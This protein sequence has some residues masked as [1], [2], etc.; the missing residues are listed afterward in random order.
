MPAWV[1]LS[2]LDVRGGEGLPVEIRIRMHALIA[3]HAQDAWIS[4]PLGFVENGC[5]Q[6]PSYRR[7]GKTIVLVHHSLSIVAL[8]SAGRSRLTGIASHR[9]ATRDIDVRVRLGGRGLPTS[10]QSRPRQFGRSRDRL[11]DR[12]IDSCQALCD[13]GESLCR[14]GRHPAVGGRTSTDPR[15]HSLVRC[16]HLV[17]HGIPV[18]GSH[19]DAAAPGSP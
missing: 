3:Q 5:L 7:I 6:P 13:G 14:P 9:L 11:D 15:I 10:R 18:P 2:R 16:A 8:R 17:P 1:F 4:T 19:C 12:A